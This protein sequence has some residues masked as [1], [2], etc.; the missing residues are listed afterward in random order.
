VKKE[1][2]SHSKTKYAYRQ[3]KGLKTR[4][5]GVRRKEL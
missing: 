1:K 4:K 5:A 2:Y 3:G